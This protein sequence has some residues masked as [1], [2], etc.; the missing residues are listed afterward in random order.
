MPNRS[1]TPDIIRYGYAQ[2]LFPMGDD[3][4]TIH[5]YEPIHRALLP[6]DGIH[7]SRSLAKVIRRGA[8]RVTFNS[9]FERVIRACRRPVDNWINDEIIRVFCEIHERGW[10]HSGEVWMDG[11]L[12]GGIYGLELGT[13]FAAESMFHRKTNG[14]KLALWAMVDECRRRGFTMFDAELMNPHL[15]S[16]GA[17]EIPQEEYVKRLKNV[18]RNPIREPF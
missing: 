16:L 14:S 12:A 1:L 3:D 4:G 15:R 5:W 13:C 17:Y 7:V 9:A 18:L 11:E 10:A 6:I 8:F 2:G